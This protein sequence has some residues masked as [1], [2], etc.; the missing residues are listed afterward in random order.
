MLVLY[1]GSLAS[2]SPGSLAQDLD[3]MLALYSGSL[4]SVSS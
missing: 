1:G 3:I 2:V 4:A